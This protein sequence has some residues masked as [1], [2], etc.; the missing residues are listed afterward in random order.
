[1]YRNLVGLQCANRAEVFKRLRDFVCSRN[2]ISDYTATGLGWTYHDYSYAIDENTISINDWFVIYSPGES[3]NEDLY[4]RFTYILNYIKVEGFLYWSAPANV[5]VQQ[6]STANNFNILEADVPVLWIYGDLDFVVCIS[7]QTAVSATFYHTMFGKGTNT[8]Y[9]DEVVVSGSDITAGTNVVIDVGAVPSSWFVGMRLFLRDNARID[10]T[11]TGIAAMT[12][13]TVTITVENNYQAGVKISADISYTCSGAN[14]FSSA[15]YA[16]IDHAGNKNAN[17]GGWVITDST[18]LSYA[19]PEVLNS[20]H[21]VVPLYLGSAA[22]GVLGEAKNIYSRNSTG[23][24][25]LATYQDLAGNSYR[26]FTLATNAY[27]CVLEV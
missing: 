20:E 10:R 16:I 18:L 22:A 1:M 8:K 5:G 11:L 15:R 12:A 9:S 24:T 19:N 3:G 14:L 13:S 6:Y 2:G 26:A 4:F 23:M 17:V 25:P 21:F 7:R 27:V